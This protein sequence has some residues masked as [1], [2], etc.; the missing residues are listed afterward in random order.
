MQSWHKFVRTEL[1]KG[2]GL[3]FNYI[4]KEDKSHLQIDLDKFGGSEFNPSVVLAEQSENWSKYWAP[5]GVEGDK[6]KF[7]CYE[8]MDILRD[9]LCLRQPILVLLSMTLGVV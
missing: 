9:L 7:A 1:A 4:A 6:I 8:C 2:G 5:K 3:L